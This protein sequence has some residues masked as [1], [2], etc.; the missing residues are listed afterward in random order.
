MGD[1]EEHEKQSRRRLTSILIV[2]AVEV[3]GHSWG[4]RRG[5]GESSQS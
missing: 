2:C 4:R 1:R 3:I 5:E